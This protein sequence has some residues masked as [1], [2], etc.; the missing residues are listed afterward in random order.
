MSFKTPLNLQVEITSSNCKVS[1]FVKKDPLS[2]TYLLSLIHNLQTGKIDKKNLRI[3]PF[4]TPLD[5][6]ATSHLPPVKFY[7]SQYMIL[8]QKLISARIDKNP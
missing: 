4:K 3:V 5:L 2:T 6:Q 1:W 7:G 8:C